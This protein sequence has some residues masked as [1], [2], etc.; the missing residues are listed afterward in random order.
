MRHL[1]YWGIVM[2]CLLFIACESDP[3]EDVN[4]QAEFDHEQIV[5]SWQVTTAFREGQTTQTL[6][7]TH[8]HFTSDSMFTNLP[9]QELPTTYTW[10][11]GQLI[12]QGTDTTIYTVHTLK[13]DSLEFSVVLQGSTF[14]MQLFR[15]RQNE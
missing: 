2:I 10:S 12:R 8:F 15:L 3:K 9:T 14:R 6:D 1:E 4:E 13:K 5:G 11:E 7:N